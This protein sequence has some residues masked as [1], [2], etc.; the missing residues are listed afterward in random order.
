MATFSA[1]QSRVQ[2]ELI[3]VPSS[4]VAL[5]PT[6]IN[7]GILWVQAQHN[8]QVMQAE[9]VY[10]TPAVSQTNP[11]HILGQIPSDWKCKREN[12]YFVTFLGVPYRMGWQASRPDM[13]RKWEAADVNQ[14]GMPADLLIGEPVNS[15][16]PDPSNPDNELA[17]LNIEFYPYSDG[18]SD[19]SDGNYRIHLPYFR[20]LA[21]LVASGDQNWFTQDGPGAEFCVRYAVTQGFLFNE[22]E[23]RAA[24][25]AKACFG[26]RYDGSQAQTLGGWSR[27]LIDKDKGIMAMPARFLRMRRDAYASADQIRE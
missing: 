13:Y 21:P 5:V 11:T 14:I 6:W 2:S 19:W 4:L 12:P 20:Y 1:M 8:F 7:A 15:T 10:V 17:D 22:D 24:V 25:H 16:Y 26:A 9:T 23:S 18:S 27:M 3:D